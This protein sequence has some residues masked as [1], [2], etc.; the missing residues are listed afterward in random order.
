[1]TQMTGSNYRN[2][3]VL[4]QKMRPQCQIG[5]KNHFGMAYLSELAKHQIEV[6]NTSRNLL[7][8]SFFLKNFEWVSVDIESFYCLYMT[9]LDLRQMHFD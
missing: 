9:S 5:V 7:I 1:M 2:L 4:L 8:F 6:S 3:L